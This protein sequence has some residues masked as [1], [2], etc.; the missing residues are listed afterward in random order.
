MA[1]VCCLEPTIS[2]DLKLDKIYVSEEIDPPLIK[3][4]DDHRLINT[5]DSS[6]VSDP[7]SEAPS[8]PIPYY[9][10]QETGRK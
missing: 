5:F 4:Q 8:Q 10:T 7:E 3:N 6:L 2:E 9:I 1:K